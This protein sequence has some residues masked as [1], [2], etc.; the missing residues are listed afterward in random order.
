MLEPE[1]QDELIVGIAVGLIILFLAAFAFGQTAQPSNLQ[2]GDLVLSTSCRGG[3]APVS[4]GSLPGISA[5]SITEGAAPTFTLGTG[6][7]THIPVTAAGVRW[8]SA[9]LPSNLQAG[10]LILS[11]DCRGGF[12]DV[13]T[14]PGIA[15]RQPAGPPL[16]AGSAAS[17]PV[18]IGGKEWCRALQPSNLE[19]GDVVARVACRD[20]RPAV[21]APEVATSTMTRDA[22]GYSYPRG[23]DLEV[24]VQG[25]LWCER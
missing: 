25:R 3:F 22:S 10:D 2:P 24:S 12:A 9:Q 16:S 21:D 11:D 19:F 6:S 4:G 23:S 7:S 17:V 5:P 15:G 13:A 8:C 14:A 1:R 20:W 18:R